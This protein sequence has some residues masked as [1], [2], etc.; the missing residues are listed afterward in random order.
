[1]SAR[2]LRITV[3][4]AVQGV[5]FRPF[6]YRAARELELTGR[7]R[8]EGGTVL[9]EAQGE[10]VDELPQR[11]RTGHPPHARVDAMDC[12]A[13]EPVTE[14]AFEIVGSAPGAPAPGVVPDLVTCGD[15]LREVIDASSRF[16]RYPFTNC[17]QCG[18]RYSIIERVPYDRA[19]TTMANFEMCGVCR[20]DYENPD[21][22]RFHAQPTACPACGPQLSLLDARGRAVTTD[23]AIRS[24]AA[25]LDAG[26][27]VALK[28]LGGFQLMV[29]AANADAIARLRERK[30]RSDKPL[31]VM[32]SDVELAGHVAVI[33][34]EEAQLLRSAAGPVVL[35][36]SR[37][38]L[39]D[40]IA[41]RLG[42]LGVML[43]TTPLHHLLL[44]EVERPVVCTSGNRSD[45]PI[46]TDNADALE[47]LGEIADQFL[48]HDR[49]IRRAVDDSVARVIDG[50]PQV[51]RLARGFAPLILPLGRDTHAMATGPHLK[52]SLALCGDGRAV[53]GR[54]VGDLENTLAVDAMHQAAADL[55][56]FFDV[57]P[58][59]VA[60]DLHPDY[61]S[62]H[63]A[64]EQERPVTTVQHHLAHALACMLEHDL[65]GPVLAVVWDGTGL[66]TDGTIW[67]GEFLHVERGGGIRWRRAAH[68]KAFR[69]PGGDA[70]ARDARR[71]L[72]GL[73][74]E[75]ESLRGD[76]LPAHRRQ[77]EKRINTP[78]CT[79][80]GRLFDGV[81]ALLGLCG[82]QTYEG[83]AASRLEA[84]VEPG[85]ED[86]Y[87]LPVA[88]GV[89]D[90]TS[91]LGSMLRD[92]ADGV[93]PGTI[94]A[95]FHHALADAIVEV[96]SD[97]GESTVVLTGGCFQNRYLC[98]RATN[99]LRAAGFT[100]VVP[101]RLPPNDGGVAPGQLIAALEGVG[102]VSCR[103]GDD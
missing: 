1:M 38:E 21:D 26:E 64:H 66:G 103:T 32:V 97:M 31:A 102:H 52:N 61:A 35:L 99:K 28:G 13:V 92:K 41:P 6:V 83:Q 77:L 50:A 30:H 33:S 36:E 55:R 24:A 81:A 59:R 5:G 44:R 22:R 95:K 57:R 51:L 100:P 84:A 17:T 88:D 54:H 74:W 9:I 40:E 101:R 73:L 8:N 14:A 89:A 48:L 47:R 39:P 16:Y 85:C 70:G 67:G 19:N 25:A 60:C 56:D 71:S 11:I 42:T 2:R 12:A 58:G 78:L 18:P 7:V 49:P 34:K 37:G 94:A 87:A 29:D 68:M 15:C 96:A 65:Q 82:R 20:A 90:W 63:F 69:L 45:E 72:S 76:V 10:R 93:P 86:A 46:C 3:K 80:A 91:M 53:V 4:G 23:D 98:E 43:P 75:V 27:V 62:S 79:S